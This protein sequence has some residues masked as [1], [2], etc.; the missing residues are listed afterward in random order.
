MKRR[1]ENDLFGEQP[2]RNV[3]RIPR[4]A[5]EVANGYAAPPGTGPATETCSTCVHCRFKQLA[6]GTR[7]FKCGR[8]IAT[9]DRSRTTDVLLKSPACRLHDAGTPSECTTRLRSW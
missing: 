5:T 9:W 6:N 4:Y 1:K 2:K 3:R 8:M 7:F